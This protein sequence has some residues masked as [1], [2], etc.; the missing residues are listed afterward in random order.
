L[1][2][3][4]S[5]RTQRKVRDREDPLASTRD[6]CATQAEADTRADAVFD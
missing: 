6:G 4:W 3:R 2:A 1:C 5:L